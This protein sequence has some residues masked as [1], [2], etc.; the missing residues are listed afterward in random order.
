VLA[1]FMAQHGWDLPVKAGLPGHPAPTPVLV[2]AFWAACLAFAVFHGF[3]YGT[4]TAL[5]MDITTPAV[6]A[7]QFTAYMA[8]FNL[9]I[10]YSATWQGFAIEHWGFPRT[11]ALDS[12]FGLLCLALLPFLTPRKADPSVPADLVPGEDKNV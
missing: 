4:R 8:M 3:M 1:W 5:F 9:V 7:T 12:A 10:S 11:L 2:T 6:A